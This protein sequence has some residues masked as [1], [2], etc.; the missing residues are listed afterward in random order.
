[1]YK[2]ICLESARLIHFLRWAHAAVQVC[3]YIFAVFFQVAGFCPTKNKDKA[4][5][6][7]SHEVVQFAQQCIGVV[8]L[9][10][11]NEAIID[12]PHR[13][14]APVVFIAE[15]SATNYTLPVLLTPR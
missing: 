10:S 8:L 13:R 9:P 12:C 5:F 15:G 3:P 4:L 1:M 14:F 6:S 11:L 7:W 2:A